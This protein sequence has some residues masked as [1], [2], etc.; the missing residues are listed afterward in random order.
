MGTLPVNRMEVSA[1]P[2]TSL[3]AGRRFRIK[4]THLVLHVLLIAMSGLMLLP[5]VW[6]VSTSLKDS[7]EIFTVT[8]TFWPQA[9]RWEN[10][11][12]VFSL[13]P[14]GRMYFNTAF[15]T[16]TRVVGQLLVASLAAFAFARLRFPGRDWLFVGVLAV[17]MVPQAVMIVPT[18]VL[19]KYLGWLNTYEGLIIPYFFTAFGTFLLRQYFLTLPQD[20]E[21]ASVLDGCNPLQVYWHVALPLARP[22]LVALGVLLSLSSWNDFLWPL[23]ITNST[24]MQMLAVGMSYLRGQWVTNVALMMAAASIAVLPMIALFVLAQRQLIEGITLTGM[25]G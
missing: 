20:L 23:I 14:F 10:Y 5:F 19:Y 21:D 2:Q 25:Q 13:I 17:M 16:L 15:I 22:A 7:S 18:Y 4:W 6:M 1:S 24:E 3:V 9:W 12:E 11:P 8:P